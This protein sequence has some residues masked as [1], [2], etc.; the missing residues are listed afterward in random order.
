MPNDDYQPRRGNHFAGE[1]STNNP[2]SRQ[3]PRGAAPS[4][5]A[6]FA[7][8]YRH[9]RSTQPSSR[10]AHA[11]HQPVQGAQRATGAQQATPRPQQQAYQPAYQPAYHQ[12]AARTHQGNGGSYHEPSNKK[13]GKGKVI[14][15]VI[16]AVVA[17]LIAA[18]GVCGV[19]LYRDARTIMTQADTLMTQASGIQ[20][21]VLSGDGDTVRSTATSIA[22]QVSDIHDT[23][24]GLHWQLASF[25]PVVGQDVQ[26]ARTI[27]AEMDALCQDALLPACDELA[28]MQ[29][30]NLF[31][32]GAV[33]VDL[34]QSLVT[35]LQTVAP[36]VQTSAATIENLPD[37]HISQLDDAISRIKDVMSSANSALTS[38]NEIAPYLPQMLGANGQTR[39]Y[40]LVAQ[41]NA[42]LRSTG[43]FPGSVGTLT[44]TDGRISLGSFESI[45][46]NSDASLKRYD[47]PISV[48]TPEEVAVFGPRVGTI[49]ADTNYIVDFSRAM[50]VL[51]EMWKDQLGGVVDGAI[52]VDP[53]FLQSLLSLTGG[54]NTSFGTAVD[55]TNAAAILLHDSYT[56]FDT[57]TQD[58][59]YSEVA[60]AAFNQLTSNLGNVNPMDLV[61]TITTAIDE[62]RF[63]VWMV[64]EDEENVMKTIGC[65]GTLSTD[66]T[67]PELGVYINDDTYSKI[68][69]YLSTHTYINSSTVNADGS[70]TYNVT[71]TVKNN[72]TSA[73]AEAEGPQSGG[74]ITGSNT[75][76]RD[77]S[78]MINQIYLVAPAG[79]TISDVS[80]DGT[81][82]QN[83]YNTYQGFQLYHAMIQ[84]TA[85]ST[86]IFTYNVTTAPDATEELK[87]VQTPTAQG[88]A[89]WE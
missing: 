14:A 26:S 88:I 60:A 31:S 71:T 87:I 6:D 45:G 52:A 65:S 41:S 44:I 76:K 2:S 33:N 17:V 68:S 1:G 53:V 34:I 38:I 29:L 35:T 54:V 59:F 43:G 3:A 5:T 4:E 8:A 21:A 67:A 32:D 73:I 7:R 39:T 24:D 46:S 72:I 27:I 58:V 80:I 23:T 81:N 64:N 66:T 19:L 77:I 69:W 86:T 84:N 57:T 82:S 20:S 74:Y 70:T 51:S 28:N 36:V 89:G 18:C 30:S 83:F 55:G 16:G 13:R 50:T 48:V 11:A 85:G 61:N 40:L 10:S 9:G 63:Q 62:H 78:D 22:T 15:G 37:A 47:E 75:L 25:I 12:G 79:G 42:E 49:P 56:M